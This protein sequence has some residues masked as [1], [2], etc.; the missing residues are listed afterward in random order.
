MGRLLRGC[1]ERRCLLTARV[2]APSSSLSDQSIMSLSYSSALQH[3]IQGD[4]SMRRGK[5]H[6]PVH[7]VAF[8]LIYT[9]HKEGTAWNPDHAHHTLHH[10]MDEWH[11][12][13][14]DFITG[15]DAPAKPAN[16]LADSV[17]CF[18]FL[19]QFNSPEQHS[20]CRYHMFL[21]IHHQPTTLL[22]TPSDSYKST[23]AGKQYIQNQPF[24]HPSPHPPLS[25]VLRTRLRCCRGWWPLCAP[26][27]L[28]AFAPTTHY[29]SYSMFLQLHHIS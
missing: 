10:G 29:Y 19:R 20:W 16:Q 6:R 28:H 24:L 8:V 22:N 5:A 3:S 18:L 13:L 26:P 12:H 14:L 15:T 9:K 2:L 1:D 25:Y 23:C 21:C 17:E 27:D 4:H 7:D 11:L